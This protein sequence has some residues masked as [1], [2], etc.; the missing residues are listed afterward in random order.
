MSVFTYC[1]TRS[2]YRHL[3]PQLNYKTMETIEEIRMIPYNGRYE[4]IKITR[5]EDFGHQ[6]A[7]CSYILDGYGEEI[8]C[9]FNDNWVSM[10]IPIWVN[11]HLDDVE[12][13]L[14][15]DDLL[16]ILKMMRESN[17]IIEE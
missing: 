8:H 4:E 14:H 3:N 1:A 16:T 9:Y 15:K 13:Q 7:S 5:W 11:D 12:I 17:K 10:K 6:L 2:P